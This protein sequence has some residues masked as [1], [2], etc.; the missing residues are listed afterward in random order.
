VFSFLD[1]W[2]SDKGTYICEAENQFGK[3]QSQTTVTVTGLGK[4]HEMSSNTLFK[5]AG[6]FESIIF[7]MCQLFTFKKPSGFSLLPPFIFHS[8]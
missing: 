3:I 8:S 2:A 4:I 6:F 7:Y 1:L 5:P